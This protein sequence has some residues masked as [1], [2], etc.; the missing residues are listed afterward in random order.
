MKTEIELA[1]GELVDLVFT[2][3]TQECG[4]YDYMLDYY[5]PYDEKTGSALLPVNAEKMIITG[6]IEKQLERAVIEEIEELEFDAAA[7]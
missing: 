7:V 3:E 1:S 5:T 2:W 6:E 4:E